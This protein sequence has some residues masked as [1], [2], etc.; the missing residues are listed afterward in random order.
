MRDF[1]DKVVAITG[2]ATGIGF[3]FAKQLGREGARIAIAGLREN[4]L[5]EAEEALAGLG[6]QAKG[7]V[8]DVSRRQE[9]EHFADLAWD[10]FGQVDVIVNNAGIGLEQ[11]P[12]MD[13]PESEYRRIFDV[14]LFGVWNGVSV[15]GKRFIE[16]GTPA[17]IYNIGSENSLFIAVPMSGAYVATKHAVLAITEALREEVPDFISVGLICPG[18]VRSEIGPPEVMRA[19]MDTDA[20]TAIAMEQIKNGEFFIVSHAYNMVRI[21]DRYEEISGAYERYAPRYEGDSEFDVRT[22]LES[23]TVDA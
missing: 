21:R 22:L 5:R 18:F 3:S 16:Q 15:F 10:A 9:V 17:G 8:C 23:M 1:K 4:R 13:T 2:G 19:G 6:I 14:N 12:V 7:W 20:Y 11:S